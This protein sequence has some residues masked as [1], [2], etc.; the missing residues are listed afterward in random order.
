[1][2]INPHKPTIGWGN[3]NP[4]PMTE[5][6]KQIVQPSG[7]FESDDGELNEFEEL[8]SEPEFENEEPLPELKTTESEGEVIPYSYVESD[9]IDDVT[10]E[11]EIQDSNLTES[12]SEVAVEDE[13]T[14]NDEDEE[15]EIEIGEVEVDDT[16]VK[17]YTDEYTEPPISDVNHPIHYAC[18]ANPKYEAINVIEDYYMNFSIG[19]A[20]KYVIRAGK[21]NDSELQDL[22]KALWYLNREVEYNG[23]QGSIC[24]ILKVAS[25]N[26]F[27]IIEAFNLDFFK[28]TVVKCILTYAENGSK[29]A[30]DMAVEALERLIEKVKNNSN[31]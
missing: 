8:V 1:M 15:T 31:F 14:G 29:D 9:N 4:E 2:P 21:K 20:Y 23:K 22:E 28:G 6:E 25:I 7:W 3:T 16:S 24:D 19:N 13:L 18:S 12:T 30:L 26:A 17:T 10:E 5:K 11:A 27:D